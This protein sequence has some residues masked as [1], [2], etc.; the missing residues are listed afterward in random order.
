[1][2]RYCRAFKESFKCLFNRGWWER[3]S[4]YSQRLLSGPRTTTH[5]I[6]KCVA[7]W[8]HGTSEANNCSRSRVG[9]S[10]CLFA[11]SK[12]RWQARN[13]RNSIKVLVLRE[14]DE[15]QGIGL[16]WG[17]HIGP[18]FQTSGC[19]ASIWY[20]GSKKCP[21]VWPFMKEWL[22]INWVNYVIIW[23]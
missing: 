17:Q 16:M 23:K 5:D 7:E 19:W 8:I 13:A 6:A 18:S 11:W 22:G 9:A 1:M 10:F 14:Q 3:W 15:R 4:G 20:S 21:N 12:W 2:T